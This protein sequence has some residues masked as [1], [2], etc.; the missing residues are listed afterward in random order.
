VSG[1]TI[2]MYA[3]AQARDDDIEAG[4]GRSP[5]D[6]EADIESSAERLLALLADVPAERLDMLVPTGR[7][8]DLAVHAV[9][10]MRL[11]EVTYH[12]VDL[13][14]GFTFADLPD[15]VLRRGLRE[16][17][18]RLTQAAPGATVTARFGDGDEVT[19]TVGDG[20][21]PV[22]GSAAEALA[23]LTGRS[24][25]TG[26]TTRGQVPLPSLPSWG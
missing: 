3:S 2:P 1:E 19:L 22:E 11:R 13:G 12:H 8:F 6:I 24:P 25:G 16:C 20:A 18:G 23:W 15:E 26:L 7:G 5:A 17:P 21:V 4:S 14:A 9:P 10:W